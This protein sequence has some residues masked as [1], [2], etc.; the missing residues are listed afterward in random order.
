MHDQ[1]P[2][3]RQRFIVEERYGEGTVKIKGNLLFLNENIAPVNT[4]GAAAGA[5]LRMRPSV[6]LLLY[7][8]VKNVLTECD[9]TPRIHS[10]H[11]P[12]AM[13]DSAIVGAESITEPS[14]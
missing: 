2:R 7:F 9:D 12:A 14:L 5:T 1:S 11:Q 4:K 10:I 13:A 6:I 8:A 3:G